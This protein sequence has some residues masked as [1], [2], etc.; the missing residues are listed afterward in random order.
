MGIP[1]YFSYIIKNYPNIIRKF[2]NCEQFQH[3]FMDCN[4]IVYDSYYE[5]EEIHKKNPINMDSFEDRLIQIVIKKIENYILYI[6]PSKSVFITFDGVA[7]FAKMD[8]QRIRR[9]K[10]LYVSKLSNTQKLWNT[11]AITPGT[12]F[13][14]KLTYQTNT[15]FSAYNALSK[16]NIMV[17]CSDEPGEGE[18]KLFKYIRD[19]DCSTDNVAIYGLDS[20]LIMLSIFHKQF[21]KNI[22]VFREAPSFK[23]VISSKFDDK[24]KLFLDIDILSASI[25]SEMGHGK[26]VYCKSRIY[27]YVFMCFLLGNDFLPHFPS[28]NIRTHGFQILMD[29][30]NNV[31]GRYEDR[32]FI[33]SQTNRIQWKW[34]GVFL[35]EISKHEKQYILNEYSS[36]DKMDSRR[37]SA[38]TPAEM[39]QLITNVPII[40]RA[41]EKYICPTE[42]GWEK[43]Y[44]KTLFHIEPTEENIKKICVN[45][46]E[47]LEWVFKYYT[48]DCPDWRWKYNASYPPLLKDLVKYVPASCVDIV[49]NGEKGP[50]KPTTQLAYVLPGENLYL[51]GEKG[52]NKKEEYKELYP[53]KYEFVWAFCRYFWEAH[54]I[55]PEMGIELLEEWDL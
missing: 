22:F 38:N 10:T 13:M 37:W 25:F 26:Q 47:G 23:S 1:S 41:D 4:S 54:P 17:S 6:S 49:K 53:E 15:Y 29:T 43:R 46:L 32:S 8:Q 55:L 40:Y 9:Y 50:F 14:E 24:E 39:D 21:T 44:Y 12:K 5:L 48:N 2:V 52:G 3:L 42:Q 45:Y 27:D 30:Y 16:I 33:C 34:I 28:L 51:I 18:H 19:N 35:T 36:R 11:S 20:D 31:I 7:P